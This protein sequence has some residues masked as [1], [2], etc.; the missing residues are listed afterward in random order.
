MEY[1]EILSVSQVTIQFLPVI[2]SRKH[3]QA[4]ILSGIFYVFIQAFNGGI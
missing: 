3:D 1:K 2:R 4:E